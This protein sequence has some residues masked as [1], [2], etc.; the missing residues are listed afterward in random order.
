MNPF[1]M[2]LDGWCDDCEQDIA[3]CFAKGRC[4]GDEQNEEDKKSDGRQDGPVQLL[5]RP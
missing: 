4:M 5:L 3:E 2:F 1:V